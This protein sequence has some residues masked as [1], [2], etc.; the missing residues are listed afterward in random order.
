LALASLLSSLNVRRIPIPILCEADD[1]THMAWTQGAA[2]AKRHFIEALCA[3]LHLDDPSFDEKL[4]R[5][6]CHGGHV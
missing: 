5:E 4:F 3:R 2:A 1:Q 6:V